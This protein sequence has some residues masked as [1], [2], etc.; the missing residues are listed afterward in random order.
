MKRFLTTRERMGVWFAP[1][2][3]P[4][5][6]TLGMAMWGWWEYDL[7]TVLQAFLAYGVWALPIGGLIAWLIAVVFGLPVLKRLQRMDRVSFPWIVGGA[8][9]LGMGPVLLK[10]IVDFLVI[11]PALLTGAMSWQSFG[12]YTIPWSYIV[13]LGY[14]GFMGLGVGWVFW[15]I[16]YKDWRCRNGL[17]TAPASPP[18]MSPTASST[19]DPQAPN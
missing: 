12:N 13:L 3:A 19:A 17:Q 4:V 16:A 10:G 18:P 2:M 6:G 9:C 14:F 8:V 5:L 7:L 15:L 11:I 1:L